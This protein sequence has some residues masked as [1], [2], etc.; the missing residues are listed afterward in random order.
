[1]LDRKHVLLILNHF[2]LLH[3]IQLIRVSLISLKTCA[4]PSNV[5]FKCAIQI[6]PRLGMPHSAGGK[7][8][9]LAALMVT[10][11]HTAS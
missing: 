5:L 4:R 6:N 3:Q 11:Y 2:T 10:I 7:E 8:S 1:M 9:A